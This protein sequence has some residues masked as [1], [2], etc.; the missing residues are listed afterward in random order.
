[1]EASAYDQLDVFDSA[2]L[3]AQSEGI[4]PA[5]E[6]SHAI[7]GGILEAKKATEE[8]KERVILIGLSGHG[9]LDLAAYDAYHQGKLVNFPLPQDEINK[10]LL[11]LPKVNV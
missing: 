8:G 10:A 3:F 6:S 5:P 9:F 11:D 1:M 2:V 4:I 7:H